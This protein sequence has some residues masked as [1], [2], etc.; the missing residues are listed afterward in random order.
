MVGNASGE[1]ACARVGG[2]V[3]PGGWVTSYCCPARTGE[4]RNRP[5]APNGAARGADYETEFRSSF[6]VRNPE[7]AR[8]SPNEVVTGSKVMR[9]GLRPPRAVVHIQ[10]SDD[11]PGHGRL[12]ELPAL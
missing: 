3:R 12:I 6:V 2:S 10:L 8:R 1:K 4:G 5:P 7:P 11:P 9:R